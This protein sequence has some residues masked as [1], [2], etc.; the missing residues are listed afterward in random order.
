M[1]PVLL[2]TLFTFGRIQ[3]SHLSSKKLFQLT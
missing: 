3:I 1:Q 2:K